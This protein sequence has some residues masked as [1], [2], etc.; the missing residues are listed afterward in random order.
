MDLSRTKEAVQEHLF[1]VTV[2]TTNHSTANEVGVGNHG[3]SHP[4][5]RPASESEVLAGPCSLRRLQGRVCHA[6][7][8][9]Q[10]G[11]LTLLSQ[12]CGHIAAC[13]SV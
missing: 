13:V 4:V 12:L 2:V 9:S 1:P 7:P 5:W 3:N 10:A 8:A 6:V 11:G